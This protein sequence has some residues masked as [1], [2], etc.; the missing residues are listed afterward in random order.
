MNT[1]ERITAG[2]PSPAAGGGALAARRPNQA[3]AFLRRLART[4]MAIPALGVLVVLIVCAVFAGPLAPFDPVTDQIYREANQGPSAKHLLGT[5]YLGRDILSRL[6]FGARV[7]LTVGI[8]AVAIALVVGT[9]VGVIGGYFRGPA[10]AILMRC[11]DA[12]SAFPALI[13]TLAIT[14]ALGRGITNAMIAIGIVSIPAF[15]RLARAATLSAREA[16]YVL[17]GRAIGASDARIIGRYV[18]PNIAAPLI[19]Q[20]SLLFAGAISIEAGLSFLGVGVQPPRPSWGVDLQFGYQYMELNPI[21]AFAPGGAIF[22]TVLA[23][24]FFG[25]ALRVALDPRLSR[26]G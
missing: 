24:N 19:V 25:D 14:S 12:I 23:C 3:R 22:I 7:S 6:L 11:V 18:L 26:R 1:S 13:L 15:A 9:L 8:V 16:D 2:T 17:A 21:L 10:D 5:D 20:A 4:R